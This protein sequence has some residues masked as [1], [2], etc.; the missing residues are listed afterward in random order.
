MG[1]FSYAAYS[2]TQLVTNFMVVGDPLAEAQVEAEK[3]VEFAKTARVGLVVDIVG[4]DLQLIRTLR[5]L[6][7]K[8]GAFN[9]KDFDEAGFEQHPAN[10][11]LADP[12]FGYWTLKAEARFF[13]GDY[14]AAVDASLKAQQLLWA[15]PTLLESAAF[16]FYGALSHAAAG[17]SASP[18]EKQRHFESLMAHHKE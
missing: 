9:N 6:T 7:N 17:D 4:S 8:F 13:A 11:A 15:A 1:D 12:A 3:G 16:R 18:N 2:F 10:P 5:G 14:A